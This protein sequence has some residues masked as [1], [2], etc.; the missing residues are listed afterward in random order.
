MPR[1]AVVEHQESCPPALFGEWLEGAG[2]R[3]EVSRPYAGGDLPELTSYDAVLVLGGEMSANDDDTVAWLAPLKEQLRGLVSQAVPVLGICLGHQL[4]GAALGGRVEK[5]PRGQTVGIQPVGWATT[6]Q[7]PVFGEPRPGVRAIHWNGDVVA[8]LP[9][10][11]SVLAR[12]PDGAPQVV[13]FGRAAWGIQAH[14]EAHADVVRRWAEGD[15]DDHVRLGIDQAGALD[16]IA[17]AHAELE[18]HWRPA[19]E[20]FAALGGRA[21]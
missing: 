6:E 14:P 10:G 19:A 12:T 3:L 11:A 8:Q 7:D 5:N 1:I 17:A 2:A 16:E 4:L 20:R 15:R 21:R 18:Q 9:K 13:R